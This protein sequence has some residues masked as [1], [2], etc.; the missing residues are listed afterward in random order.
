MPQPDLQTNEQRPEL[1][2]DHLKEYHA[3]EEQKKFCSKRQE[4]IKRS[5]LLAVGV[6]NGT[7]TV[8]QHGFKISTVGKQTVTVNSAVWDSVKE[9]IPP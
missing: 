7:I 4:E 8:N 5:V 2:V 9:Q 1:V 6:K 3:L